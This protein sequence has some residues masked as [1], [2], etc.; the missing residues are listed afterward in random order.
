[1]NDCTSEIKYTYLDSRSLLYKIL[2]IYFCVFDE[3][4]FFSYLD[5]ILNWI[6]NTEK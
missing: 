2:T 5:V 3:L 6:G 1:M 4:G